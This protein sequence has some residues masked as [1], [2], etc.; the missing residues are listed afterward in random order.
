LY[1]TKRKEHSFGIIRSTRL[2]KRAADAS[3]PDN[4]SEASLA[5]LSGPGVDLVL[6]FGRVVYGNVGTSRR[7]DFTVIGRAVNEASRIEELCDEADRSILVSDT[8]AERCGRELELI[9]TFALRGLER[10]QQIWAPLPS[11]MIAKHQGQL[12]IS[13]SSFPA[14]SG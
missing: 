2:S 4:R 12:S 5:G 10:K 13:N 6:H 7:R 1:F 9:G 3:R 8:F 14:S 11:P